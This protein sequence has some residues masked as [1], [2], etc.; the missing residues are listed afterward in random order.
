MSESNYTSSPLPSRKALIFGA[1]FLLAA[2]VTVPLAMAAG[3]KAAF[4]HHGCHRGGDVTEEAMRDRM[5]LGATFVLGKI[6]ATAEQRAEVDVILDELAP[7][8]FAMRAEGAELRGALHDAIGG[9]TIDAEQL[10]Q[11][12]QQGLEHAD[13]AS[14]LVLGAVVELA[15]VLTPEQR[16]ELIEKA[17]AFHGE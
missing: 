16:A 14:R 1:L 17:E 5:D 12:R 8:L 9:E 10:E 15:E 6:D 13:E 11:L 2:V 3:P 4:G 7:E